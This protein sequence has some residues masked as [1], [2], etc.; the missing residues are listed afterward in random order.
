[1][2][3]SESEREREASVDRAAALVQLERH[4]PYRLLFLLRVVR[5]AACRSRWPCPAYVDARSSLLT[6][7][8]LDVAETLHGEDCC[9]QSE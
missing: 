7:T 5:C 1:V 6:P 3:V 4:Q 9:R 2:S 8:R